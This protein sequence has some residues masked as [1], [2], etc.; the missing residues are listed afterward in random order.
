MGQL[1]GQCHDLTAESLS[2]KALSFPQLGFC[3]S[4]G[5]RERT[6]HGDPEASRGLRN[7]TFIDP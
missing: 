5:T 6:F 1:T 2:L 4:G 7:P 3:F